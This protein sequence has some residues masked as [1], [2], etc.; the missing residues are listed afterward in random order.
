MFKRHMFK[1]AA[2]ASNPTQQA[3]KAEGAVTL[4]LPLPLPIDAQENVQEAKSF[5]IK[6]KYS[7][8]DLDV[9]A[10]MEA[11]GLKATRAITMH[12]PGDLIPATVI[13]A[14]LPAVT[15]RVRPQAYSGLNPQSA[16]RLITDKNALVIITGLT[17]TERTGTRMFMRA[18]LEALPETSK[19]NP[20]L[21][22]LMV[23]LD[24][25]K[26]WTASWISDH[27]QLLINDA[28][29]TGADLPWWAQKHTALSLYAQDA[30]RLE[31]TVPGASLNLEIEDHTEILAGATANAETLK[32]AVSMTR[33]YFNSSWT[34]PENIHTC[35]PVMRIML[36]KAAAWSTQERENFSKKI[37][38]KNIQLAATIRAET[39]PEEANLGVWGRMKKSEVILDLLEMI[40]NASGIA[41]RDYARTVLQDTLEAIKPQKG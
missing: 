19:L 15:R 29:E 1:P 9:R 22:Q 23:Q 12:P 24:P 34:L 31:Q 17:S 33:L 39:F 28:S 5:D 41:H 6:G 36:T 37:A 30:L 32:T 38:D 3:P 4:P 2:E 18:V 16:L 11:L 8:L 13:K 14:I 21:L 20:K 40:R 35:I 27:L 25:K 10:E 7:E 26:L